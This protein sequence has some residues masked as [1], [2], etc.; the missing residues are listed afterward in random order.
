[1]A[2]NTSITLGEHFDGF[3]TNQIQSGRYGSA[4]EVIRSALRLLENQETKLQTLRQLL[5]EGEQSGDA[6]YD[7]DSFIN[8]LDSET[9]R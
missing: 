6:D 8:E 4:S 2:K 3:I 5:V 9:N 1:M 7:L